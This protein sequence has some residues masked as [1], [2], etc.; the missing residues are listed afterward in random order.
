MFTG[1]NTNMYRPGTY[2]CVVCDTPLFSSTTKKF[3]VGPE[4]WLTFSSKQ[5]LTVGAIGKLWR[6]PS[7]IPTYDDIY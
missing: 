2:H 5:S 7:L 4:P 1:Y 6:Q 3:V